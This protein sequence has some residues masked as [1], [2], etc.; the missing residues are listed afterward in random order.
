[1][2]STSSVHSPPLALTASGLALHYPTPGSENSSHGAAYHLSPAQCYPK[3][4][5]VS[6]IL[7]ALGTML[8]YHAEVCLCVGGSNQT[9]DLGRLGRLDLV[10]DFTQVWTLPSPDRCP[11]SIPAAAIGCTFRNAMAQGWLVLTELKLCSGVY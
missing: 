7:P 2:Q 11:G 3:A 6:H 10:G 9:S 1:M 4:R 5:S 8:G